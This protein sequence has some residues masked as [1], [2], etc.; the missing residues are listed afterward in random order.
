M[1][2]ITSPMSGAAIRAQTFRFTGET[3]AG[4]PK[5]RSQPDVLSTTPSRLFVTHEIVIATTRSA[6]GHARAAGVIRTGDALVRNVLRT[7][8][9]QGWFIAEKLI[10]TPLAVLIYS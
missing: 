2:A 6:T 8:R 10:G 9:L 3:L 5:R 7:A 4:F 1:V